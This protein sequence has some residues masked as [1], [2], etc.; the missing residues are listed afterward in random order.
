MDARELRIGNLVWSNDG[1]F[2]R[3]EDIITEIEDM[4]VGTKYTQLPY[5]PICDIEPIPLTEEWL[6]KFG[7]EIREKKYSLN[8]GGESMKYAF[9]EKDVKNPFILYFHGRFGF[10]INEGRKNGDYCIQYIHQ[11]QN[12]FFALTGVELTLKP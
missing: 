3:V 5:T 2:D 8:Y 4:R 6:A 12:L 9:F 11:L 10:N 7:F 1:Y